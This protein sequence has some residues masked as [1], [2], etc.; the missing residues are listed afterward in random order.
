M[1]AA[2]L[3]FHGI[4]EPHHAG[5][6]NIVAGTDDFR[7][8]RARAS[9]EPLRRRGASWCRRGCVRPACCC[10]KQACRWGVAR[11]LHYA[12]AAH[13]NW[14]FGS[15]WGVVCASIGKRQASGK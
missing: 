5:I 11:A 1:P 14:F 8:I 6:N 12:S 3:S 4:N 2:I 9:A 10:V 13:F 7:V 15:G